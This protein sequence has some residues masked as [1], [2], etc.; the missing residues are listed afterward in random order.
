MPSDYDAGTVT[1]VFYWRSPTGSTSPAIWGLQGVAYAD[2]DAID[3]S[4]GTAQTVS[5]KNNAKND[6]NIT[7]ATSAIT[8]GGGP[9]ASELV[10]FRASR[11]GS[12]GSD[13]LNCTGCLVGVMVTFTRS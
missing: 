8:I 9:A 5:D 13:S 4:W 7:S 10:Q 3:A 1:A 11:V 6:M 12:S 2:S